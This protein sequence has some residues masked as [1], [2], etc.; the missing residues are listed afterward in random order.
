MEDG[1]VIVPVRQNVAPFAMNIIHLSPT[2]VTLNTIPLV[3]GIIG[4]GPGVFM[5]N[6]MCNS[7]D[8]NKFIVWLKDAAIRSRFVEYSQDGIIVRTSADFDQ[9]D[10]GGNSDILV[11]HDN[12]E[13]FGPANSCPVMI[14]TTSWTTDGV[15]PVV[16]P[17]PG[18]IYKIV[19][20]KRD[21]LGLPIPKPRFRT[22][23]IP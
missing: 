4:S 20:D 1:S 2:G 21:D 10:V 23:L 22:S 15:A 9:F 14:S 7:I 8:G 12:M 17:N 5:Y 3:G 6:R 16:V 11:P 18:G 19:P 13:H